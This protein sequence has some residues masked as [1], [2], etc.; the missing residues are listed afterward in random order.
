[1]YYNVYQVYVKSVDIELPMTY[2]QKT[3]WEH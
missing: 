3:S 1:M 2:D